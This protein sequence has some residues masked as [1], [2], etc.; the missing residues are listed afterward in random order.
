MNTGATIVFAPPWLVPGLIRISRAP[1][2]TTVVRD[3]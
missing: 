2:R 1:D 3:T